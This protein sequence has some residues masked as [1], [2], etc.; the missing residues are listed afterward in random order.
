MPNPELDLPERLLGITDGTGGESRELL[1]KEDPHQVAAAA[2]EEVAFR[3]ALF[4][5]PAQPVD[6]QFELSADDVVLEFV[7]EVASDGGTVRPGRV[8]VP[9]VSVHQNLDELVWALYGP[10]GPGYDATRMVSVNSEPGPE[11]DDPHDPWLIRW[12]AATRAAGQVIGACSP[13]RPRVREL[14][15]RARSDKWGEN[16]FAAHYEKHFEKYRDQRVKV[17]EIGVGGFEAPD[18]GGESLRLWKSY[19]HRGLIYG[20]DIFD[21]SPLTRPRMRTVQGDQSSPASLTAVARSIGDLDVIIDDGSHISEHTITSFRALFPL[22]KPGGIYVVED[23]QTSYWP[24]WNGNRQDFTDQAT[25]IGFVKSL[26]DGLHH[27]DQL[28]EKA[29][30]GSEID[31]SV[32]GIHLY[33]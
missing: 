11:S 14:A 27:Q 32:V 20:M 7:V 9:Q 16:W 17:L 10:P 3:L 29:R 33:H 8:A 4:D 28:D 2:L 13:Y 30:T 31:R 6:V 26:V 22:L 25:W 5:G 23:V 24:G 1:R 18:A 19:F 21:K 15:M 12:Q